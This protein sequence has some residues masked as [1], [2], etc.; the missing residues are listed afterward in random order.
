ML[1][2][3]PPSEA[4]SRTVLPLTNEFSSRV[5]RLTVSTWGASRWLAR[6]ERNSNSKS[7]K[8]R[9]PRMMTWASMARAKS[10]SSPLNGMMR[11]L[12]GFSSDS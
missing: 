5:I 12:P 1:V 6:A 3:S 10:T 8:T 9:R 7:E 2:T 11:M 4:I